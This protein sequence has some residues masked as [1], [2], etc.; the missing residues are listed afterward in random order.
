MLGYAFVAVVVVVILFDLGKVASRSLQIIRCYFI[1]RTNSKT[2]FTLKIKKT[3][4]ILFFVLS[5]SDVFGS[6][7]CIE[8]MLPSLITDVVM[9]T[10]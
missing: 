10:F 8:N 6:I 3:I 1:L 2:Q 9:K 4:Q 7:R 5:S